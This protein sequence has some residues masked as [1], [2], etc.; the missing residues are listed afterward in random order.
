VAEVDVRDVLRALDTFGERKLPAITAKA[1][2][3]AA[4]KGR[5]ALVESMRTVFDR[6]TPFT[7]RAPIVIPAQAGLES[8]F[9]VVGFRSWAPKGVPAG[10]YLE[11][12]VFGGMR[13]RKGFENALA[14]RENRGAVPGKWAEI[15]QYGNQNSGQLRAAMSYLRLGTSGNAQAQF[16][17]SARRKGTRK[18]EEYFIIPIGRTDSELP[19]GIY[20]RGKEYGGAPLLIVAFVR[21]PRYRTR[22][23]MHAVV[24]KSVKESLS[25]EFIR[26]FASRAVK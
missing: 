21:A 7:L 18:G 20:R 14:L 2:T 15:D 11:P 25:Q 17:G 1:L 6:P 19:P 24:T 3:R 23:P 4:W 12:Q 5:D 10:R 16:R 13:R 9:S 8:P 22:F 26:E